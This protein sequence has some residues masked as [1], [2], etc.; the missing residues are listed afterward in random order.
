MDY[1]VSIRNGMMLTKP[2][3]IAV[4]EHRDGASSAVPSTPGG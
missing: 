1:V 3:R 4:R 2:A